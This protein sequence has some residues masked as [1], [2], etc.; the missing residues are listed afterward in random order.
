[1]PVSS[2]T[3][4]SRRRFVAVTAV[5]TG[6]AAAGGCALPLVDDEPDP[7]VP[8]AAAAARDAREFAAADASHG[9]DV[10][11]LHR[12]ADARRTHAERLSAEI[13]PTDAGE[14]PSDGAAAGPPAI[15]PPIGEVRTRLRDDARRAGEVAVAA[16]GERAALA[17]AVSAACTTAVEVVLA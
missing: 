13:G 6:V 2:T 8:L 17:A 1:M 3:P 7:L 5:A 12:M 16:R 11:R 14:T 10:A 15:C 4:V 9:D